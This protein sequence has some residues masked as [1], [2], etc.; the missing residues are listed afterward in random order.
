MPRAFVDLM[1]LDPPYNLS[2]N[3]DGRPFKEMSGEKYSAW[4]ATV[5]R[6][7]RAHAQTYGYDLRLL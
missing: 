4:F 2:K 6:T 1:I 7:L 5:V 3:Y